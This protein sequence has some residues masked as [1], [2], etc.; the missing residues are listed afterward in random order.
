MFAPSGG[1]DVAA[2]DAALGR[3][4][5]SQKRALV[6]LNDPCH[7]PTGYSMTDDEW[8]AVVERIAARARRRGPS[9]CSSTA[10][11][12]STARAIR[13]P[14]CATC[15]R[16]S[17]PARARTCSSRGARASRSRTTGCASGALVACVGRRGRARRGRGGPQLLVPRH[18]VQL[19]PRRARGHHASARRS[20]DGARVRRP[21]ATGFKALLRARVDAFNAHAHERGLRYPRYEGGFFVTVFD[22]HPREK[23]EAMRAQGASTSC[24][25]VRKAAAGGALR[26]ALARSPS[27]TSARARRALDVTRR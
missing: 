25:Q 10:R 18:V 27:G 3:Q 1:L 7:N 14:S 17:R 2:L 4:L 26:V 13:A 19:Q 16:S 22:D 23:A 5:A 8:A 21:S 9:R 15:A 24:P 6:F 12:S 20:R 11:T